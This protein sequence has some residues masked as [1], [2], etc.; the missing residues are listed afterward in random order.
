[1][2]RKL[3]SLVAAVVLSAY[4]APG[5]KS[6]TTALSAQ[7]LPE[8][9]LTSTPQAHA[10]NDYEHEKPRWCQSNANQS[11]NC[12][13]MLVSHRKLTPIGQHSGA[14]FLKDFALGEFAIEIE[15]VVDGAVD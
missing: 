14:V 12:G 10:H 2:T 6:Q 8:P 3:L 5:A 13:K 1:M 11:P 4:Q 9:R 7:T 15:V